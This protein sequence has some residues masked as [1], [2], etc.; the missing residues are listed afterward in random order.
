MK[1]HLTQA[2]GQNLITS[3]GEGWIDVNRQRYRHHLILTSLQLLPDWSTKTLDTLLAEDFAVIL[4]LKPEI[5]LLGT[6]AKQR[7]LHPRITR[8]LTAQ[9][10]PVEFMDTPAACRTY[11]I[12]MAE[13]RHV[14][15]ALMI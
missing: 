4:A 6:G 11:N 3:Y 7:F 5:F 14:V 15:A 13:S 10:I 2:E 9:N 8:E 1:L 12:L